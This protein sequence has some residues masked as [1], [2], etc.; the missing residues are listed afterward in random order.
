MLICTLK[1]MK[2]G[3]TDWHTESVTLLTEPHF[4]DPPLKPGGFHI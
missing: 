4:N 2:D 3:H 1:A